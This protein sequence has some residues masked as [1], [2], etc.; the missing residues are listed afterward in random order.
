M[1]MATKRR[2][3]HRAISSS[4]QKGKEIAHD[5]NHTM[6]IETPR[7]MQTKKN[8]GDFSIGKNTKRVRSVSRDLILMPNAFWLGF[9]ALEKFYIE[10]GAPLAPTCIITRNIAN[11]INSS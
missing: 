9:L 10:I 1:A 11:K 5:D 7:V 8:Q 4:N 3:V 6:E 2:E